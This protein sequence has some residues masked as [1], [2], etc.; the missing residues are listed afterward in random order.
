MPNVFGTFDGEAKSMN[1]PYCRSCPSLAYTYTEAHYFCCI[2]VDIGLVLRCDY[3]PENESF[4]PPSD[5]LYGLE[6]LLLE[7]E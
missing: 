6:A 1:F 4:H 7:N 3:D 5:C 2:A